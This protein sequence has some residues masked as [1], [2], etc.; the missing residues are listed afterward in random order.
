MSETTERP[1]DR[2]TFLS[3]L[4]GRVRAKWMLPDLEEALDKLLTTTERRAFEEFAGMKAL[5]FSGD[6]NGVRMRLEWSEEFRMALSRVL[7][8]MFYACEGVNFVEWGLQTDD[9]K[10]GPVVIMVQ[11]QNGKTPA[12]L[13]G[14][15]QRENA[16]LRA[17]VAALMDGDG[18]TPE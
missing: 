14:E 8:E 15:A 9:P 4:A 10:F 6:E 5:T 7:I 18:R 1:M 17:Q 11:R 3:I 16:V 2:D 13:F 12:Q